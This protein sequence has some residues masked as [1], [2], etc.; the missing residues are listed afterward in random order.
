MHPQ[1]RKNGFGQCPICGMDLIPVSSGNENSGPWEVTFSDTAKKL[2]S[3]QETIVERRDVTH[4]IRVVGIV[5][6]NEQKIGN[7]TARFP[8][9]IDRLFVDFE[10]TKVRKGDHLVSIYSAELL[11]AQKELLEAIRSRNNGPAS[12][13][14]M[15]SAR[16]NASREKLRLW[17]LSGS[18]I[19]ELEKRGKTVDHI[20][21]YAPMSGIV[22]SK[23]VLEGDY[24]STGTSIYTICDLSTVWVKLDIYESDLNWIRLGQKVDFTVEAYP[25]EPFQGKIVFIDPVLTKKTRTIR[26]RMNVPNENNRLKPNMFVRAVIKARISESGGLYEPDLAGKWMCSMHFEEIHDSPGNC[27]ICGMPL[28]TTESLGYTQ[29]T[30]KA[31]APLVIPASAA[32]ITGTRAVVYIAVPGK[33]GTYAG[34]HIVL[35]PRAGDYYSVV[36]G[37]KEGER[38]VVNGAFKIDS[39]LQIQAKLSM[40]YAPGPEEQ[41]SD[42][43]SEKE[44]MELPVSYSNALNKLFTSYFKIQTALAGDNAKA[45]ATEFAA[46]GSALSNLDMGTLSHEAH[47]AW[48]PWSADIKKLILAPDT[49]SDIAAIR[50]SFDQL[51]EL[52]SKATQ[53]FKLNTPVEYF[54]FHCPMAFDNRGADWFQNDDNLKNPYYGAA[55]LKCGSLT[56]T[57]GGEKDE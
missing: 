37:L 26:V 5:T 11:S 51:S 31:K 4:A 10:G 6:P 2:A 50:V 24:I 36:S 56:E 28:E 12:L 19:G 55:M 25:G 35:G 34:R 46:M 32:L 41:S 40:M 57:I 13:R 45:A 23:N 20:T 14:K 9:R 39:E 1:I 30:G 16:I 21:I 52:L 54:R 17:Q 49:R 42:G 8:G 38:V 7:I 29:K 18:Q 15:A 44:K 48:M 22:L 53:Q 27:D 3:I 47:A 43:D 33:P